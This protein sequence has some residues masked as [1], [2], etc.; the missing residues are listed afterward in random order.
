M[1]LVINVAY[2][3]KSDARSYVYKDASFKTIGNVLPKYVD[4]T[5]G[6]IYVYIGKRYIRFAEEQRKPRA[7]F[8]SSGR[9]YPIHAYEIAGKSINLERIL[10]LEGV[11]QGGSITGTWQIQFGGLYSPSDNS[12]YDADAI[13]NSIRNI[14][15]F[16]LRERIILPTF[17][18]CLADIIGSTMTDG[19]T[20]V[21]KEMVEK[22]MNWERRIKLEDVMVSKYPDE[23]QVEITIT[24]SVPTLR[25]TAQNLSMMI[26]VT[27]D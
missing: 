5:Q 12:L 2:S 16:S 27:D 4:F 10:G 17:G 24:Y 21:V 1:A 3:K 7:I 23:Y 22:M 8:T 11:V 19:Q 14:F 13:R 6:E 15:I 18:S 9:R 25:L 26:S 20:I